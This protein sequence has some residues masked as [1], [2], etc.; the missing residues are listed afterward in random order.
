MGPGRWELAACFRDTRTWYKKEIG[1]E[2]I[3]ALED[4]G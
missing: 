3:D 4:P 2:R 1:A